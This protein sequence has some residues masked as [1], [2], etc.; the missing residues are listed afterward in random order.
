M[1]NIASIVRQEATEQT[2]GS[3]RVRWRAENRVPTVEVAFLLTALGAMPSSSASRDRA[4][5]KVC[6][7][8][9]AR[10]LRYGGSMRWQVSRSATDALPLARSRNPRPNPHRT[11]PPR[12]QGVVPAA[13]RT[14]CASSP[15]NVP[16]PVPSWTRSRAPMVRAWG[17]GRSGPFANAGVVIRPLGCGCSRDAVGVPIFGGVREGVEA[18]LDG[19]LLRAASAY[20][21][22]ELSGRVWFADEGDADHVVSWWKRCESGQQ[23][24][25]VAVGDHDADREPVDGT[26]GEAGVNPADAQAVRRS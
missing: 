24:A 17:Y 14:I 15:A 5:A 10:L 21:S 12:R 18:T 26:V 16:R 2:K 1:Y 9:A 23:A 22:D 20:A 13:G 7:A 8:S 19:V 4:W 6:S 11:A 25:A 3:R